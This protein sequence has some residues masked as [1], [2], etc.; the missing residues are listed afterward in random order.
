[1][2]LKQASPTQAGSSDIPM[3]WESPRKT[4]RLETLRDLDFVLSPHDLKPQHHRTFLSSVSSSV[5]WGILVL[6]VKM[7]W[8]ACEMAQQ[9]KGLAT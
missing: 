5:Q 4:K 3:R 7:R 8:R 1:M 9:I 2:G 6:I